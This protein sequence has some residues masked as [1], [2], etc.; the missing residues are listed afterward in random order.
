MEAKKYKLIKDNVN[1]FC[2]LGYYRIE[3]IKDFNDVKKGD[4]GGYV[5][6]EDN[7]SQ[8]G[9]CWIYDNARVYGNAKVCDN[10]KIYGRAKIHGNAII[11]NNAIIKSDSDY[12]VFKNCCLLYRHLQRAR[13]SSVKIFLVHGQ[14]QNVLRGQIILN[15]VL[16]P[17]KST[18]HSKAEK[19]AGMKCRNISHLDGLKI[20]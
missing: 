13:L 10:A 8:Y 11:C 6:N 20:M 12:I 2:S 14:K 9:D 19:S 4:I 1:H 18:D 15:I 16:S 17:N 3:A 5:E 7:L